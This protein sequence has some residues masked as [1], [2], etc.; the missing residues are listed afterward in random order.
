[1]NHQDLT[2]NLKKL[3]LPAMAQQYVEVARVAD[4]SHST[5]EEYLAQMT[6][7][8]ITAKYNA[9]VQKL[10]KSAKI[11]I[12]KT[13]ETYDFSRVQGITA[14]EF[15]RLIA[16]DFLKEAANLVFFGT[17][18][19]GKTHLV[20]ALTKQLCQKG[21]R[22]HFTTLHNLIDQLLEA[23]KNLQLASLFRRIDKCDLLVID[24]LGYLAQT[25]DGADLFFQLI[26]QRYERKSIAITTNLTYSEWDKVFL[27]PLNT[28]AA[29]D[30]IIH[31]CETFNVQ[32][33]SWRTEAAKKRSQQKYILTD[34]PQQNIS[35]P[36]TGQF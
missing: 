20:I 18:G 12:P 33:P 11:P 27:N 31:K 30:R 10:L 14:I 5:Y 35:Q 32:A 17:M 2:N 26:S 19:V 25:Q 13:L 21:Y 3:F 9:R 16:G 36:S 34:L 29:V 8:E 28:A 22:C 15:N 7:I 1:M 4:K 6:E 23:K 24:E